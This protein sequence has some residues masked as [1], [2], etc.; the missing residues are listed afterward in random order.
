MRLGPSISRR[1]KMVMVKAFLEF[2]SGVGR[3][4]VGSLIIRRQRVYSVESF[5]L[6]AVCGGDVSSVEHRRPSPVE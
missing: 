5:L 1:G 3:S 4:I 6:F 2:S